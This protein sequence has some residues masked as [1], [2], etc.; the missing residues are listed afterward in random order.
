MCLGPFGDQLIFETREIV[1]MYI[2][3]PVGFLCNSGRM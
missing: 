1:Y 2:V 3:V